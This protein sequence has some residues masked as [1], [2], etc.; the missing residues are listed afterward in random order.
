MPYGFE[1]LGVSAR[2]SHWPSL[3]GFHCTEHD[4]EATVP[5]KYAWLLYTESAVV[6]ERLSTG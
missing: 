4:C 1:A 3:T 6:I 2:R 5:A